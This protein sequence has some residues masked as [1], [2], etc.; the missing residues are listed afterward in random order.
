MDATI[1]LTAKI[2]GWLALVAAGL[3]LL[4]AIS[5]FAWKLYRSFIGW[6]L[7]VEALREHRRA[8]PEKYKH[9]DA[10]ELG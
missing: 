9:F 6:P 5:A 3:F 1:I 4:C 8:H 7:A 10:T 2:L